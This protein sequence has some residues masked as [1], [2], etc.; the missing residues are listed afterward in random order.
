MSDLKTAWLAAEREA[1]VAY[2]SAERA[3]EAWEQARAV[4][5]EKNAEAR[6]CWQLYKESEK[7]ETL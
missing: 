6:R 4:W 1:E 7:G 3:L 2:E 5:K